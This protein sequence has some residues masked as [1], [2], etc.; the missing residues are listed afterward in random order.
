MVDDGLD[1]S[2]QGLGVAHI[3]DVRVAP[4]GTASGGLVEFEAQRMA[5]RAAVLGPGRRIGR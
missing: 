3:G 4:T 1:H 5:P 2:A